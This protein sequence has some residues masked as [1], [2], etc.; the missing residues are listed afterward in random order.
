MS[1]NWL[2]SGTHRNEPDSSTGVDDLRSMQF[3]SLLNALDSDRESAGEKYENLR[4]KLIKFFEWNACFP[5]EDLVDE[6]FDRIANRLGQGVIY[7]VGAFAWGVAKNI[8]QEARRRTKKVLS[9]SELPDLETQRL[10]IRDTEEQIHEEMQNERRSKYLRMC[11]QRL[12]ESERELFLA[13]YN[14]GKE[15]A[16]YRQR[17]AE[18]LGLTISALRVRVNRLRE[19]LE[20]CVNKRMTSRGLILELKRLREPEQRNVVK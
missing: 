13:Y 10:N 8:R 15:Y 6:A 19:K 11:L 7:D 18:D 16:Q 14:E 5:A 4:R 20:K 3:E 1:G 2:K 12:E 17:L 9:I